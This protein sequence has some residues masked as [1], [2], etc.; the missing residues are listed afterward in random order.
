MPV[1]PAWRS[2]RYLRHPSA[3]VLFDMQN[4]LVFAAILAATPILALSPVVFPEG[5]DPGCVR[6]ATGVRPNQRQFM[7]LMRRH[8]EEA[9][10]TLSSY[11]VP[12]VKSREVKQV[13]D[14]D[15]CAK[16][17]LAYARALRAESANRVH[18]L[19]VGGRFVVV[20]PDYKPDD[21][22]R[23]ITFDSSFSR[24]LAV[25]TE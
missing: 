21:R 17:A 18:I 13:N 14:E 12:H 23:V 6:V 20:A 24:P 22:T 7:S 15:V 16:A 3:V 11:A 9:N 5:D 8:D 19:H 4:R 25:V 10:R 2:W 1:Y